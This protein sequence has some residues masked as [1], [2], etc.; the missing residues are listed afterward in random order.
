MLF[1][2][3]STLS[4]AASPVRVTSQSLSVST[5]QSSATMLIV[6][7][8]NLTKTTEIGPPNYAPSHS[9]HNQRGFLVISQ[10]I[11]FLSLKPSNGF[12]DTQKFM[13]I[14]GA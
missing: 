7:T 6:Q 10:I 14:S 2:P 11:L 13:L 1:P 5:S 12:P 8:N 3:K 4:L 9:S